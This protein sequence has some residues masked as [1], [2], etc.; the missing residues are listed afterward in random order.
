MSRK[1]EEKGTQSREVFIGEVE[2]HTSSPGPATARAEQKARETG[3]L[4]P[5][6]DPAGYGVIRRSL[7]RFVQLPSG[8]W[9][10]AVGTPIPVEVRLDTTG[11]MGGN[12]DIALR[13]LPDTYTLC[14]SVLPECDLQIAIGIFGDVLDMFVLCRPQF[15][16]DARKIVEQLTLMVP[17]RAGGDHT[18]DP[19][20][21]LF[22]AAYLTATYLERLG[23]KGYDFTVSD[24]DGREWLGEDQLI[25]V[26]GNEI[27]D[28]V[29]E[30]GHQI[31]RHH[32]PTTKEVV[33]DLLKRAHAF[34]LQVGDNSLVTKSWVEVFG[35]NR[36]I[37]LPSTELLPL[38]Q[39]VIIGLTEGT[40]GLGQVAS[41]LTEQGVS[42]SDARQ[43]TRSVA[44]I[45]I[46]AQMALPNF[47]R[48]PKPGALFR[49]KTDL[50]PIDPN[51]LAESEPAADKDED[52]GDTW[53]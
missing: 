2:K 4:H 34:F 25:R 16:M 23:Q 19:Q 52:D 49:E 30:N 47:A 31:N 17:E 51:E 14:S 45:P 26:F 20:Y 32:L 3:R 43:I 41:F 33:Q 38:V 35:A 44:N 28:K 1:D 50:W 13:V 40:L 36:V 27:F 10:L 8:P 18:E 53:L 12:V 9:R 46:G 6:V 7:P 11:S 15:E 39:A 5:L 24:E 37:A 29:L 42:Q 22:G 21:G 48:R